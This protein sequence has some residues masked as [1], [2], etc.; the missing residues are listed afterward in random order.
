MGIVMRALTST[1]DAEIAQCL[2]TLLAAAAAPGSWLMHESFHADDAA[3]FTR[4][5]FAWANSLF[6]G[7]IAK[8]SKER[9]QL[10]GIP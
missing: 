9:P 10:I 6:G 3:S 5:W 1:S 8:L 7:L 2:R 4:P